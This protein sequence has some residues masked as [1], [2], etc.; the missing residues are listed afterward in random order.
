MNLLNKLKYHTNEDYFLEVIKKLDINEIE[1][2]LKDNKTINVNCV[3]N[4][5]QNA[6]L[7]AISKIDMNYLSKHENIS[8]IDIPIL[9]YLQT[10]GV[11]IHHIDNNSFNSYLTAV[12]YNCPIILLQIIL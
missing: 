1:E 5:N 12:Q 9:N 2:F 4:Q 8:S 3:N 10:I 11:N 7:I 6:Y